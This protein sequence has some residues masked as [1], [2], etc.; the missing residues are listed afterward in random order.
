MGTQVLIGFGQEDGDGKKIYGVSV[1]DG[2]VTD[3]KNY[4][5]RTISSTVLAVGFS[6]NIIDGTSLGCLL[7]TSPS[8][9]D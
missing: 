3:E 7:Y 1:N 4:D 6:N 2:K 9:R 8:P 5:R